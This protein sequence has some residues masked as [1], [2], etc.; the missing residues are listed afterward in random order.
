MDKEAFQK[1]L[2]VE[3][4]K[5]PPDL[6]P[7][8]KELAVKFGPQLEP[9][10]MTMVQNLQRHVMAIMAEMQMGIITKAEIESMV[11]EVFKG[12]IA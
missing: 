8:L 3:L 1:D 7:I 10:I 4:K 12:E 11:M 2:R 9:I 5:M 6:L